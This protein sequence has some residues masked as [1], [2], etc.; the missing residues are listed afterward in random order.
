MSLTGLVKRSNRFFNNDL[1][2]E[3]ISLRNV[4]TNAGK[5]HEIINMENY[6]IGLDNI[7]YVYVLKLYVKSLV[8]KT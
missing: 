8:I 4:F 2:N 6:P 3:L 5:C 1:I 7:W